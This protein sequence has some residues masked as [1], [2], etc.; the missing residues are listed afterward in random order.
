MGKPTS[1]ARARARDLDGIIA[2]VARTI[3]DGRWQPGVTVRELAA[4]HGVQP[5]RAEEWAAEAG[6][7]LRIGPDVE[8]YRGVNL[9]R[10]DETYAT[11][12]D[13]KTRVAAIAEQNKMLGNHAPV[14]H[15]VDVSVQAYAKLDDAQMLETVRAQIARLQELEAKLVAKALP[16]ITVMAEEVE[17]VEDE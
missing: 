14:Q 1:A 13:G 3:V 8:L 7:L 6:R 16:A 10:L 11:A 9:R 15:K 12:E 17:D 4:K 2:E 5:H